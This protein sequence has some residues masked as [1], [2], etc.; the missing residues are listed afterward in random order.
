MSKSLDDL[1]PRFKPK[2][3]EL[4]AR[5]VELN[6]PVMIIETRRSLAEHLENLARGVSWTQ[7]SKHI[8]GLAI[9][10]CPYSQY[11]VHGPSKLDWDANDPIWYAI[12]NIG[13]RLGMIW[14]GSWQQR[15]LGHFE[16]IES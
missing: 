2:A 6:I 15:D 9:D 14:G 4:L 11:Q 13:Q 1:D 10:I 8:D 3:I 7:H 16:Y 5:C 12:G